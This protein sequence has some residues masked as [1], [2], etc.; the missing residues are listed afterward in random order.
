[1]T[2]TISLTYQRKFLFPTL[3]MGVVSS[4]SFP[5]HANTLVTPQKPSTESANVTLEI[6]QGEGVAAEKFTMQVATGGCSSNSS[7]SADGERKSLSACLESATKTDVR[8][9]IQFETTRK[10]TMVESKATFVAKRGSVVFFGKTGTDA[11]QRLTV[12]IK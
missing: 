12:A 7:R 11:S 6:T 4:L 1:M 10:D 5:A 8:L 2:K 9:S 3:A